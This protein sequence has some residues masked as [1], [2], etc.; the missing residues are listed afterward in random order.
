[1]KIYV[2]YEEYGES[3][4]ESHGDGE[5]DCSWSYD[6]SFNVTGVVLENPAGF[7]YET[8]N[9]NWDASPGE[10]VYV[11]TMIYSTGDSFGYASGKGEVLWVF[12]DFDVAKNA[13]KRL[14]EQEDEYSVKIE[15]ETGQTI[16]L[17][18]PGSGYFE[19]VE[20]IRL[21]SFK[22]GKVGVMKF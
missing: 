4:H 22:L 8:L 10:E 11:L 17:S 15:D 3:S 7:S 18:N 1:M 19:S 13:A 21:E 14:R 2:N 6:G 9:V 5:W 20:E 16:Q 12:K